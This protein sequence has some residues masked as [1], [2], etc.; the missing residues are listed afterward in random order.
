MSKTRT[1]DSKLRQLWRWLGRSKNYAILAGLIGACWTAYNTFVNEKTQPAITAANSNVSIAGDNSVNTS[2]GGSVIIVGTDGTAVHVI[3]NNGSSTNQTLPLDV[4]ARELAKKIDVFLKEKCIDKDISAI[5]KEERLSKMWTKFVDQRDATKK[6]AEERKKA[7]V[8]ALDKKYAEMP[9]LD[10]DTQCNETVERTNE[11][12][13]ELDSIESTYQNE[14][15]EPW[16]AFHPKEEALRE[17]ISKIKKEI[18]E[19][20]GMLLDLYK[21]DCSKLINDLYDVRL[22]DENCKKVRDILTRQNED[23][24]QLPTLLRAIADKPELQNSPD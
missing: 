8:A 16:N 6:E 2:G 15:Y 4:R 18:E 10:S 12:Q 7:S 24:K 22:Y 21:D 5:K 9:I 1:P 19:T 20:Y 13:K 11:K 3:Q 14:C 23:C 17:E